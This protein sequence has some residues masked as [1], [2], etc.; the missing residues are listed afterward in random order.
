M[1]DFRLCPLTAQL[2]LLSLPYGFC[3][4]NS[5]VDNGVMC[6]FCMLGVGRQGAPLFYGRPQKQ[7]R[8]IPKFNGRIARRA[9]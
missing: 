3:L 2:L 1:C 5:A 9:V 6:G 4:Q 7:R 8:H